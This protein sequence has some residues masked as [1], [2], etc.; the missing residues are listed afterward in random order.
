MR[1]TLRVAIAGA[2]ALL[3]AAGPV[4]ARGADGTLNLIVTPNDGLP[5]LVTPGG[6]FEATLTAEAV[7]RVIGSDGTARPVEAQWT[8]LPGGRVRGLCT[9]PADLAPGAYAFGGTPGNGPADTNPRAVFVRESFPDDYLVAHVTDTHVGREGADEAFR[10]MVKRVNESQAAFALIT[11]DLTDQGT[12]EQFQLFLEILRGCTV[13]TYVCPGNHD[14]LA[15]HYERFFGPEAYMFRFGQDGYLVFDTKDAVTAP[16][17]GSQD[18]DL[19][20]FR[21]AI[22]PCRWSIGASHRYEPDMGMR[23]QITLFVDDPLDLFLAGHTHRAAETTVP[24]GAT[25]LVITPA[26]VNGALR[27]IYVSDRLAVNAGGLLPAKPA[28]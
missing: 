26:A 16:E 18:G 9:L 14:R 24:W 22:K 13:P 6:T 4:W 15:L 19:Y 3:A 8:E 20:R 25:R 23:A 11:G 12:P 7:L 2:L 1:P 21:R 28:P 27:L 5:A 17:L 10:A